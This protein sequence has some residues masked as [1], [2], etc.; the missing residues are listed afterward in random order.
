MQTLIP[1]NLVQMQKHKLLMQQTFEVLQQPGIKCV[2]FA[3]ID[4]L[5]VHPPQDGGCTCPGDVSK[6]FGAGADFVMLGGML[7]GHDESGGEIIE[8]NGKKLKQFYGMASATAMKKYAGA[9][10]EYRQGWD[11]FLLHSVQS[12]TGNI[13]VRLG[14]NKGECLSDNE[15][16]YGMKCK[17]SC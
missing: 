6:A 15:F 4:I 5:I 8:K 14:G 9:V 17:I 12:G 10:A 13:L 2:K 16:R 7:A 11:G 3:G 1:A